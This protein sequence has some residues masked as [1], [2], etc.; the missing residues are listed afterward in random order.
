MSNYP[1]RFESV[2]LACSTELDTTVEQT[3][4]NQSGTKRTVEF[5]ERCDTELT[6]D[7]HYVGMRRLDGFTAKVHVL[8]CPDCGET[9]GV[10]PNCTDSDAGP[11]YFY[12]E[13]TN[14]PIP[15]HVCNQA[16]ISRRRREKG[17]V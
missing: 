3:I 8:K 4:E 13:S 9:Y 11:G 15:C 7:D 10:C 14:D 5:P 1:E 17:R 2:R 16:E 12:G 6:F